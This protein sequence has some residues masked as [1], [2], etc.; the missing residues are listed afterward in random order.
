MRIPRFIN[1]VGGV[2]YPGR[3]VPPI[4][5][6]INFDDGEERKDRLATNAPILA[7]VCLASTIFCLGTTT[8]PHHAPTAAMASAMIDTSVTMRMEPFWLAGM[9]KYGV[10]D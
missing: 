3:Q 5:S 6:Q 9:A 8:R 7:C 4:A 1:A 10:N 2:F